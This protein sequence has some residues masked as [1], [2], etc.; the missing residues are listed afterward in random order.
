MMK[1]LL[2]EVFFLA[3]IITVDT[4]S[5]LKPLLL[6]L[7]STLSSEFGGFAS[8]IASAIVFIIK[9]RN[10][11]FSKG[12]LY[13]SASA[14][15]YLLTTFFIQTQ[16]VAYNSILIISSPTV[17]TSYLPDQ[18]SSELTRILLTLGPLLPAYLAW[19]VKNALRNMP[20]AMISLVLFLIALAPVLAPVY[21]PVGGEWDRVLMIIAPL[22]ISSSITTMSFILGR[23]GVFSLCLLVV[24]PGVYSIL[25]SGDY[26]NQ[27][28]YM[29]LY[30]T[31]TLLKPVP[32]N[33]LMY[34]LSVEAAGKASL[35]YGSKTI[36][37]PEWIIRFIHLFVRN[38]C[39]GKLVS[40]NSIDGKIVENMLGESNDFI[41][42][43]P[44][45]SINLSN[46]TTNIREVI[47]YE[48]YYITVSIVS[49]K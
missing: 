21:N 36:V 28:M 30:R 2:A 1:Q 40:V 19:S 27:T 25:P 22:I 13:L 49:R 42:V 33:P 31:P 23:I 3:A 47:V 44:R 35:F 48:N 26:F 9:A 18:A 32:P 38:P 14:L 4:G 41:L 20:S 15:F 43:Y 46:K 16:P 39:P 7:A 37:A 11:E 5:L 24:L 10:R 17:S 6:M 45:G 8:S 34:E 29:V 12:L